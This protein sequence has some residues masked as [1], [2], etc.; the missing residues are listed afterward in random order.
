MGGTQMPHAADLRGMLRL[1][2]LLHTSA[3]AFSRKRSLLAGLCDLLGA[4]AGV[5]V[6]AHIT[7]PRRR[8]NIV[9]VVRH[10]TSRVCEKQLLGGFL[11]I[12]GMLSH[13]RAIPTG[14]LAEA[15]GVDTAAIR[16]PARREAGG[17]STACGP[18]P[19]RRCNGGG[20]PVRDPDGA[21]GEALHGTGAGAAGHG[22]CGDELDLSARPIPHGRRGHIA[23]TASTSNASIP[24]GGEQRKGDRGNHAA[25]PE[26]RAS[27]REGT[28]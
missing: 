1:S 21:T 5:N 7:S 27:S 19:P 10:G 13:D 25:E 14:V 11:K 3:D 17:C 18:P 2:H 15:C 24:A 16:Q 23:F 20:V 28:S 12:P 26:H 6:V 8:E 9:S 22:S 4:D